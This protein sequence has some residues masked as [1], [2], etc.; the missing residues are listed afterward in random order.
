MMAGEFHSI[1][2]ASALTSIENLAS[3]SAENEVKEE[4]EKE[5]S[6]KMIAEVASV[7]LETGPSLPAWRNNRYCSSFNSSIDIPPEARV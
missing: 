7:S 2:K 5:F 6:D 4:N 3:E 1:Q